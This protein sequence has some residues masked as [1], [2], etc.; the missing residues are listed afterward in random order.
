MHPVNT[1]R[2]SSSSTGRAER[3][4]VLVGSRDSSAPTVGGLELELVGKIYSTWIRDQP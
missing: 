1:A 2:P 4:D 3:T